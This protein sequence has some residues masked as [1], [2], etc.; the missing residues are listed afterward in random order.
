MSSI[1]GRFY[2][3]VPRAGG[4]SLDGT[5]SYLCTPYV[6]SIMEAGERIGAEVRDDQ[7]PHEYLQDLLIGQV[8][9]PSANKVVV[10][11]FLRLL[12]ASSALTYEDRAASIG[13]LFIQRQPEEI[14]WKRFGMEFYPFE[15]NLE[16]ALQESKHTYALVD[17][18]SAA[19]VCSF[20]GRVFGLSK[21]R[22]GRNSISEEVF[23]GAEKANKA[24]VTT[25]VLRQVHRVLKS[26]AEENKLGEIVAD[27][28]TDVFHEAN[29]LKQLNKARS[30]FVY[31]LT[32]NGVVRLF[33]ADHVFLEWKGGEWS[34][35]DGLAL[36]SL[37]AILL[38]DAEV[39]TR[40]N[41]ASFVDLMLVANRDFEMIARATMDSVARMASADTEQT[42][43]LLRDIDASGV[44]QHYSAIAK[45]AMPDEVFN[46]L[47]AAHESEIA[48]VLE[49]LPEEIRELFTTF[50]RET[51]RA[52]PPVEVLGPI[53]GMAHQL[54]KLSF[55]LSERRAGALLA[56]VDEERA[57]EVTA[58]VL[59]AQAPSLLAHPLLSTGGEEATVNS[60]DGFLLRKMCEVDGATV[61]GDRGGVI[62]FGGTV[63]TSKRERG[64]EEGTRSLA[65][66]CA[67][68]FGGVLFAV[69]VS[70]DGPIGVYIDGQH[71]FKI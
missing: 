51:R 55:S 19:Y 11:K 14:N 42:K 45:A 35:H 64:I 66:L 7:L 49:Q 44:V 36:E 63:D 62:T 48:G 47:A 40:N 20:D 39:R 59:K 22:P 31:A 58:T 34:F 30:P 32:G 1:L 67:S 16:Q 70:H 21:K 33:L 53:L 2:K 23:K 43:Q 3:V 60:M 18:L 9:A 29:L 17:G 71:V 13:V 25:Q 10:T 50:V 46:A 54:A 5:P 61:L 28:Y 8:L 56:I 41:A 38:F 37:F 12:M 4:V 52:G 24:A 6:Q 26:A 57:D 69:K 68:E 65:A 27:L 15:I